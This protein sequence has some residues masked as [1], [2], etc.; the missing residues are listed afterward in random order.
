[1][2]EMSSQREVGDLC[3]H[4]LQHIYTQ[5]LLEFW[6]GNGLLLL[7]PIT[8]HSEL[9]PY[10]WVG[11]FVLPHVTSPIHLMGS[12]GR[13]FLFLEFLDYPSRKAFT[14]ADNFIMEVV[15]GEIQV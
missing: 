6:K 13:Q 9:L 4:F 8:L 3:T 14:C 12:D 1:M 2:A 11:H 10:H 7:F 5:C 15:G